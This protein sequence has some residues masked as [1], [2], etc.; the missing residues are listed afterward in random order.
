MPKTI[1]LDIGCSAVRAVEVSATPRGPARLEQIGRV[2]LPHGAVRDGEIGDPQAVTA[3][4][5]ELWSRHT[6]GSK[7]VALG[8]ANQQVVVRQVDLP[9][10]PEKELR[11]SLSFQA[12]E[13]IPIPV[14]Q[15]ILDFHLLET[16]ETDDGSRFSRILLVAAQRTMVET[17]VECVRA[18]KLT[19][20]LVDLEAFSLLRSLGHTQLLPDREGEMLL[21]V[22]SAVTNIVVHHNG[23]P[24]F[25]RILLMGG[26]GITDSLAGALG[27]SHDEAE[28]VKSST[29]MVPDG[30]VALDEAGRLVT[31]RA[32][33]FV[34]EIRGSLDYYAAQLES[35]N[36]SR[37][38][39]S[40]GGGKLPNLQERLSSVL[41]LPVDRGHPMQE[42]K[43][44]KVDLDNEELVD[45]EPYLAVAIGLALGAS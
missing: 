26:D 4:L 5:K 32:N 42:L 17:I 20:V 13:F 28:Q 9:Y 21:D 29:G 7:R 36:V 8:L 12:Q 22:G 3:A 25:V 33:R 30:G 2:S 38:V 6:F 40:G 44:G 24:K 43:I 14:E 18:A 11:A 1:G 37:V 39:L 27:M 34:E 16:Y 23:V 15:A 45:A 19:P 31:E 35:I 41:G 10:L